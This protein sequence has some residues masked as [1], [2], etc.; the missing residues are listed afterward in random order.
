LWE[1]PPLILHPFSSSAGTADVLESSRAALAMA[2]LLEDGEP[3]DALTRKLLKG[4]WEEIR[5][6]CFIGKDVRRWMEQCVEFAASRPT[7]AERGLA[8][9]S[10]SNLLVRDPP[11]AVPHK[12]QRWGVDEYANI[13][14]RAVALA[15]LFPVPP[16]PA[17]LQP[18]FVLN[19]HRFADALYAAFLQ[20][21]AWGPVT[22]KE[23]G[24]ALYTSGEYAKLLET[25]WSQ[26][27]G[28]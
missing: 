11:P 13:F 16:P 22:S 23:F 3:E 14:S 4:R 24:F 28:I 7:L 1:L 12:L 9:Q 19:Y 18:E 25:E 15:G 10:F 5:M 6:L 2:G 17:S 20:L 27:T 26:S 21:E 8:R